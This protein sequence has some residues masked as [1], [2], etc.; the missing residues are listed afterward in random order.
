MLDRQSPESRGPTLAASVVAAIQ[1]RIDS[2]SLA[3]GARLP[4]VRGFAETMKVS[5]STVVEAYDRLIAE[6]AIVARRGSGFYVA[7]P[8]RPLSLAALGPQLERAIDPLWLMRQSLQSGPDVL[9]PGSGWLP[10]SWMPDLSIQRGLRT[11]ARGPSAAR[12]QY[13]APLGFAPLR[14]HHARRL[15]ERG[16][17]AE[18]DHILL[19]DSASQSL[20]M[21]C[22]F[23]LEPGDTVLVDDPCYFNFLALL[24]AHRVK[25]VGV[26]F[27]PE[28]PDVEAFARI[29]AAHK[30]R[31]YLTIAGLH[32]PT[33]ATISPVVAHRVLK[34][35]EKHD[36]IIIEDD[37]FADFEP[38]PAP[39]F[40]GFDGFDRVIQV[41]SLSKTVSAAI[42][43]GYIVA[44]P[45]WIEQLVDL[46]LAISQGNGHL[47]AALLHRLLADGGHRRHLVGLRAKLSGAMG[48]TIRRLGV[49]GLK[50]WV[51]PRGGLFLWAR[52]PDGLDA[53][54]IARHGLKNDVVFAP[55]NVFSLSQG[56]RA[57]LRFNVA[58]CA[59]PR[60]FEVLEEAMAARPPG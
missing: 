15:A 9:K 20:D 13:D 41:G 40:A 36:T 57:F 6:G 55:G 53:A 2:R 12:I 5:K 34:L 26:P 19:T 31:F 29:L 37:I 58:L 52:L 42:R 44:R 21:L 7:G 56:G 51:E 8:T 38:E 49:L 22:R 23:L 14:L 16:V 18:P 59:H 11:L 33:G 28:G 35:A 54:D 32:N 27:T 48:Q 17:M 3:P 60:I 1:G 39:R 30:P 43:C 4:S 10:D 45:E 47:S 46:K 50:P 24:R 25:A